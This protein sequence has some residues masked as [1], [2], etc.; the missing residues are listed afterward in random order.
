MRRVI[1]F[2]GIVLLSPC[3][4]AAVDG[5]SAPP[6]QGI[7]PFAPVPPP[8]SPNVVLIMTDD[9]GFGASSTFGGPVP[10]STLD[11][12]ARDGL[13]FNR[14][15]T[16]AVCSPSRAALLT[17]RNHDS[18]GTPST[19]EPRIDSVLPKTAGTIAAMLKNSGYNTAFFGK[20]HNVPLWESGPLGPFDRWPTGLGFDYF[21]GFVAGDVDQ[22]APALY[23]NTEPVEPP[24]DD[25]DYHF[26]RALADDAIGWVQRQRALAGDKPFFIYYAPAAAHS[27]HHAPKAWL[28]K[29]EGRFDQG[30][31]RLREETLAR[32]KSAGVVPRDTQ[33]AARPEG[34]PAWDSLRPEQ[35]RLYARMM[36]AFAAQLAYS[37]HQVGRLLDA[38]KASGE[39]ENTL[40]IFVQGDNGGSTEGSLQGTANNIGT[41]LNGVPESEDYLQSRID[42][43]GGPNTLNH[44][45][46]GWGWAT[47]APFRWVKQVASDFGGTRNG[48][49]I[50]WPG[51][52]KQT[53]GVRSQFH[54]LIDVAPTILEAVGIPAPATLNGVSQQPIEGVSMAYSFDAPAAPGRRETQYFA[55]NGTKGIYHQGWFAGNAPARTPWTPFSPGALSEPTRGAEISDRWQLFNIDQDFSLSTDLAA[56]YP[57]KLKAL[58]VLWTSEAGKYGAL[59]P[60]GI[61]PSARDARKRFLFHT[62]AVR[63]PEAVAPNFHNKSFAV[64]ARVE[65]PAGGSQGVLATIGGRFGGWGFLVLDNK[66]ALIGVFSEQ[67]QHRY[68]IDGDRALTPGQHTLRFEFDYDGGGLGKGGTGRILVDGRLVGEGRIE[69]TLP[70]FYSL[71]E[72]FDVGRDTGTPLTDDYRVPFQFEGG[73]E[74]LSVELK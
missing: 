8:N 47:S 13:R 67:P 24:R 15:H 23:R 5:R 66:P 44:F 42:D 3:L 22:W 20:H 7:A 48:L 69:N 31:D 17:G 11:A 33:L 6:G 54:H 50:S 40:V 55:L 41:Y 10:T 27:P 61:H 56:R 70:I 14:F 46:A 51:H 71:T 74:E 49:V 64:T 68:R 57:E 45:P 12:L 35:R 53:G 28:K 30:W 19:M 36:E 34:I 29:F 38:I 39:L 32:Q 4:M 43:I 59:T 73:L 52:I 58:K 16:T 18:V 21:F 26:E 9:V 60:H 72:T 62:G 25:P 2:V 63:I 37:D 65:V 1:S